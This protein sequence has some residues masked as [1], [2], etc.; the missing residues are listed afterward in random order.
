M[1][2]CSG[3]LNKTKFHLTSWCNKNIRHAKIRRSFN[4][5]KPNKVYRSVV[6]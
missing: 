5:F 4:E 6:E 2:I 3:E 1:L